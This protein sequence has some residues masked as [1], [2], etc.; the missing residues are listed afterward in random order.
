MSLLPPPHLSSADL[1]LL[2]LLISFNDVTIFWGILGWTSKSPLTTPFLHLSCLISL[3]ILLIPPLRCPPLLYF[4]TLL[5]YTSLLFSLVY[6][7][8]LVAQMVKNLP[9]MQETHVPSLERSPGEGSGSP[10]QC[11]C[12][13]NPMDRGAWPSTV[14]RVAKNQTQ[15]SN[16]HSL[17]T[18][19]RAF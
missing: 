10:L 7:A 4:S 3:P 14:H 16:Y 5:L 19:L 8:F 15:L 18:I 6:T 12:L 9:A 11:S 13:E 2:I 1:N 17:T